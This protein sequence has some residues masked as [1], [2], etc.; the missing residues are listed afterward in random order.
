M[1]TLLEKLDRGLIVSCQPVPHGPMDNVQCVIGFSLAAVAAGACG[2]RI[3]SLAYVEAVRAVTDVPI[4]GLI[5]HDLA[6][7]DVRITPRAEMASQLCAAGA[8]IVAFDATRRPRPVSVAEMITEIHRNG[9]LAMADCA[10]ID[11]ARAALAADVD[12]VGSTLSGYVGTAPASEALDYDLIEKMAQ[13]D[14][15]VIAEGR[16]RSPEQA[17]LALRTGAN[18]I[19]VGSAITRTEHIVSWYRDAIEGIHTDA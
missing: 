5:K 16:I 13:L 6:D 3:E 9:A 17:A 12:I 8:D 4:V 2:L 14:G 10:D 1:T 15:F 18:A 19:V 7:Y 11:D